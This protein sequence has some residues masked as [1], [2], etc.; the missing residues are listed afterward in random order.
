MLDSG[1]L[2]VY[3]AYT[4][5]TYLYELLMLLQRTG[6]DVVTIYECVFTLERH[7]KA[8]IHAFTPHSREMPNRTEFRIYR[9]PLAHSWHI[10]H[11]LSC[12]PPSNISFL[13]DLRSFENV[14]H[15]HFEEGGHSWLIWREMLSVGYPENR[16]RIQLKLIKI[17]DIICWSMVETS[18]VHTFHS[19][20]FDIRINL[21]ICIYSNV[22]GTY[23]LWVSF[24]YAYPKCNRKEVSNNVVIIIRLN[25]R[26]RL[27]RKIVR[28]NATKLNSSPLHFNQRIFVEPI[29]FSKLSA[30]TLNISFKKTQ[31]PNEK[32]KRPRSLMCQLISLC[33]KQIYQK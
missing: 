30:R 15:I 22:E 10:L 3:T 28:S 7:R 26:E 20:I 29:I 13:I 2:C 12:V 21:N 9:C 24:A 23:F 11:L 33:A 17:T 18:T 31:T 27:R 5:S 8:K 14:L 32:R 1:Y 25:K 4:T 6:V 19:N 16:T